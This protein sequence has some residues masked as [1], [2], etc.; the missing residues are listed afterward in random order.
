MSFNLKEALDFVQDIAYEAGEIILKHQKKRE[1]LEVIDKGQGQGIASTAD[2]DSETF[3]IERIQAKYPGHHILAEESQGESFDKD[4]LLNCEYL[5][6]IDPLDGTNNFVNGIPIFAVSIGLLNKGESLLGLVYNPHSGECF[7]AGKG[8][9]ACLIDYRIN[10]LKKYRLKVEQNNKEM[11]ECIF[12]P[13]PVYDSDHKFEAQLSTFKK[14]IVGARAV[15]RLG[16]AALELCYV[17]CG[18]FDA[19]WE[20]NLMPWDVA[21]AYMICTE[22]GIKVTSFTGGEYNLFNESIIAAA[23]PIHGKIL[24]RIQA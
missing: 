7:F 15:R 17:A 2:K 16:S 10:P 3:L 5:W 14:N 6:V 11:A 12:S 24:G 4:A 21:G 1:H 19:Y 18:N 23:E 13:A 8:M 22:A 9:G 20:K